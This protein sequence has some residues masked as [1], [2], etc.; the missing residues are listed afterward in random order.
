[1]LPQVFKNG[2]LEKLVL[3]DTSFDYVAFINKAE[4]VIKKYQNTEE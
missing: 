1:M 4:K 3:K 2:L